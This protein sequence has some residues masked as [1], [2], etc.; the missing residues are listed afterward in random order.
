[1]VG[2]FSLFIMRNSWRRLDGEG[3]KNDTASFR[4]I[5]GTRKDFVLWTGGTK[6]FTWLS[7]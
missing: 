4:R 7:L 5:E 3:S 6:A 2:P 1:M